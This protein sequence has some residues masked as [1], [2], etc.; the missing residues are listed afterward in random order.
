QPRGAGAVAA[1]GGGIPTLKTRSAGEFT[2]TRASNGTES[3]PDS[4]TIDEITRRVMEA[5][6]SQG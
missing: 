3:Q 2:P 4:A 5:L 6:R 1:S